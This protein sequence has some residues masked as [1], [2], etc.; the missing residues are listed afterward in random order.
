MGQK[1][2]IGAEQHS[3][4]DSGDSFKVELWTDEGSILGQNSVSFD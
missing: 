2:Q 1:L 3:R 4:R